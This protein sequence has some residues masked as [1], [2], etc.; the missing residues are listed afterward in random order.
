MP[1]IN[2]NDLSGIH[3]ISYLLNIA[4]KMNSTNSTNQISIS[5]EVEPFLQTK[6]HL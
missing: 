1:Y 4:I 5:R 2:K 3:S 6:N